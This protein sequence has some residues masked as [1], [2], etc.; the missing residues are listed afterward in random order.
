M[1][2]RIKQKINMEGYLIFK[3]ILLENKT[4]V[5]WNCVT[6]ITIL[7]TIHNFVNMQ[8]QSLGFM[9]L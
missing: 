1:V 8:S 2:I 9:V 7:C 3:K 6:A 4:N 5:G